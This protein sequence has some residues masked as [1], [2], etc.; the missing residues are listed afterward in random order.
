[1]LNWSGLLPPRPALEAES[2][3]TLYAPNMRPEKSIGGTATGACCAANGDEHN[4]TRS[5]RMS[6]RDIEYGWRLSESGGQSER[7]KA[8]AGTART[9]ISE[10]LDLAGGDRPL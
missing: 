3:R 2:T 5:A 10:T 1:M 9:P 8:I 7:A 6:V 4:A